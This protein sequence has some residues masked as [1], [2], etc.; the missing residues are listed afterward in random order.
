MSKKTL[1]AFAFSAVW[2]GCAATH[3]P[4][5][6]TS[7]MKLQAEGT[8]LVGQA[9]VWPL[10][11]GET[12]LKPALFQGIASEEKLK[13]LD[14]K[15][16]DTVLPTSV[17]AYYIEWDD[18]RILV[19]SGRG[20]VSGSGPN[21]GKL[22][23]ALAEKSIAPESIQAVL[24]THL[25]SDHFGGLVAGGPDDKNRKLFFPN[26]TVWV[27]EAE[28]AYWTGDPALVP[29]GNRQAFTYTHEGV[30]ALVGVAGDKLQ[31][32]RS[33]QEIFSGI[34]AMHTPGH[35]PG[36]T[37]FMLESNGAKLVIWGDLMHSIR[38]QT[39]SPRAHFFY[40][41]DPDV[42]VATRLTWM[43]K[44]AKENLWIA[45]MHLPFPGIVRL[46]KQIG[47]ASCRER[48]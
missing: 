17:N 36:H 12:S 18:R 44:A 30:K 8:V 14:V 32:F 41:S 39:V 24:I 34:R 19:D 29:E 48:V 43:E 22:A 7:A 10:S 6:S 25:H 9:K 40:D 13:I 31:T 42:A 15:S 5:D 20:S 1:V 16:E 26:A 28:L 27:H 47:R 38:L 3:G 23:A 11:D 21:S 45:G 2:I 46:E 33:D 35:T 4:I 37:A